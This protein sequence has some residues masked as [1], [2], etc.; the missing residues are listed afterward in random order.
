MLGTIAKANALLII[1]G[2]HMPYG[3]SHCS[4]I[5]W[6]ISIDTSEAPHAYG[7]ILNSFTCQIQLHRTTTAISSFFQVAEQK[8]LA[9]H[10]LPTC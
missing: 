6:C 1:D 5:M 3:G 8:I 10:Q 9:V 4:S 7:T 2:L